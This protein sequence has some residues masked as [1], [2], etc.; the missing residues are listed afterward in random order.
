MV[1]ISEISYCPRKDL[2]FAMWTYKGGEVCGEDE[3]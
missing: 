2:S 1:L 3:F